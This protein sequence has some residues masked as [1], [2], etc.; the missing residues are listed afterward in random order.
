V[1]GTG[2]PSSARRSRN[3]TSTSPLS[4]RLRTISACSPAKSV[5]P[6]ASAAPEKSAQSRSAAAA[7]SGVAALARGNSPVPTMLL[8]SA[9]T[10]LAA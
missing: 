3:R 7:R 2:R 10:A 8:T 5:S 9:V 4:T 6:S 1:S